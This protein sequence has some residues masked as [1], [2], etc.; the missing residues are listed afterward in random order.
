MKILHALLLAL[1]LAFPT[2][3]SLA[4]STEKLFS[5]ISDP[6]PARQHGEGHYDQLI[7]RGAYMIDGTGAPATGPV[8][9]V[10]EKDRIAEIRSVGAPGIAIGRAVVVS[11]E[12]D[13]YAV[14]EDGVL[15]GL[16]R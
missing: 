12:A 4:Q 14:V 8:D 3:F 15:P 5:S 7:I 16:H 11:P 1:C 13:L 9:I 6:V 2:H 10:V